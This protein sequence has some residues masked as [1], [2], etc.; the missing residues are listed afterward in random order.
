MDACR[1]NHRS[2]FCCGWCGDMV[3]N[4]ETEIRAHFSECSH[5][6]TPIVRVENEMCDC[7]ECCFLCAE[8]PMIMDTYTMAYQY[9][10]EVVRNPLNPQD[11]VPRWAMG[12]E[13]EAQIAQ[14]V[15]EVPNLEPRNVLPLTRWNYHRVGEPPEAAPRG[16]F[17]PPDMDGAQYYGDAIT[18]RR[19]ARRLW[20]TGDEVE[21]EN[22][23]LEG[24][25]EIVGQLGFRG[26]S[27]RPEGFVDEEWDEDEWDENDAGMHECWDGYVFMDVFVD[28]EDWNED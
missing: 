21:D 6:P 11:R 17:P 10:R 23:N 27:L 16:C 19:T 7:T 25:G 12:L 4:I 20:G 9:N 14:E 3:L 8:A 26:L 24:D 5:H 15:Y 18:Q 28:G 1:Q 13:V 2:N 22:L